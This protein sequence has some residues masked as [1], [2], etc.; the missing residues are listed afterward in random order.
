MVKPLLLL[1]SLLGLSSTGVIKDELPLGSKAP[2]AEVKMASVTGKSVSMVDIKKENGLLV[3]FSCNTCPYVL[4]WEDRYDDVFASAKANGIGMVAINS[5]AAQFDG[6]DSMEEMKKRATAKGYGFDYTQDRN[7]EIADA[8]GA[9]KT[10]HV[11]L[12]DKDMNLVYRGAIDDNSRSAEK[13]KEPWLLDA[14]KAVGSGKPVVKSTSKA[15]GCTIKR[16][17]GI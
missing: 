2:M 15:I 3:I 12:F 4:A 17:T 8:F 5:N 9:T 16:N 6:V 13:V 10:P 1:L 14:L 11:Y 7:S